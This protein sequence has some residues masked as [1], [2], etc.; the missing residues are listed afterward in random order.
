MARRIARLREEQ[1]D[2]SKKL[3]TRYL[4]VEVEGT[5][6]GLNN[7]SMHE[8][9]EPTPEIVREEVLP[10]NPMKDPQ[11]C[12]VTMLGEV[13]NKNGKRNRMT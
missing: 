1:E 13:K 8:R 3:K 7:L 9:R 10:L 6:E 4:D 11:Q 12:E 5:Q 2:K